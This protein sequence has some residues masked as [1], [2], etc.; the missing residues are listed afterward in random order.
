MAQVVRKGVVAML[1]L[2]K[3]RSTKQGL[4]P[5]TIVHVGEKPK[6]AVSIDIIDYDESELTETT[7]SKPEECFQYKDTQTITWINVNGV[8]DPGIVSAIGERYGIHPLVLEDIA[9][10]DHRPKAEEHEEYVFV[11]MK[12]LGYNSEADE[13]VVEQVSIVLGKNFVISFQERPGDVFDHVRARLKGGKRRVRMLRPDYLAYALIDAVVDNYFAL[14]EKIDTRI[15]TI[16]EELV[17]SPRGETLQAIHRVKRNVAFLRRSVWPIREVVTELGRG[18]SQLIHESTLPYLKDV[19]DHVLQVMDTIE[20][21]TDMLSGMLDT[22]LSDV[23]HRMNDVMKVLTIVATIFIPLTFLA[24]I[25]GMNFK[26]MP[27]L[28]WP[29]GYFVTL[30]IMAGLAITMAIFFRRKGWL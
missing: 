26:Y 20:V 4:P 8:H 16:E 30:A 28:E 11:V 2:T 14:M 17:S 9:N 15:E 25:Y 18:E 3:R 7:V 19:Y 1:R 27:E 23:S 13:I 24:G 12:M 10:T 5:G 21:V 29:W 22:Y 6:E